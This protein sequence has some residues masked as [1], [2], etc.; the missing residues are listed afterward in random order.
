MSSS[1]CAVR[2]GGG[3]GSDAK[4]SIGFP[5]STGFIVVPRV[6]HGDF[7]RTCKSLLDTVN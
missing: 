6:H 7:E 4:Q 3:L 1:L 5:I 2:C